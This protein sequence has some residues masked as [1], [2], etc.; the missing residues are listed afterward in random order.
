MQVAS[1]V[2]QGRA[3][4]IE[5]QTR[6]ADWTREIQEI[7]DRPIID[8]AIALG[9]QGQLLEAIAIAQQIQPDRALYSR[10]QTLAQE[11]TRTIQIAE[12][13]PI[14]NQAKDLAYE[15]K[16]TRAINLANQIAPGRALYDEVQH[17]IGL[18]KVEREYILSLRRES[19]TNPSSSNAEDSSPSDS[20]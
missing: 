3:L 19:T 7:Q 11:W 2:P 18:W 8:E 1:Q 9:N 14:F 12:D 13:Q 20:P 17:A 10:A 6:I 4:R 5:A 16:L 15:G